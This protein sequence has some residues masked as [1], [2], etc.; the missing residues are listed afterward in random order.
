[1]GREAGSLTDHFVGKKHGLIPKDFFC[2][3]EQPGMS[4]CDV[5]RFLGA[6]VR[7]ELLHIFPEICTSIVFIL[8]RGAMW[9][10]GYRLIALDEFRWR[11]LT[12]PLYCS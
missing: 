1:M 11:N 2:K 10:T 8:S 3:F 12:V 9:E 7:Y 6:I 4:H 5:Y